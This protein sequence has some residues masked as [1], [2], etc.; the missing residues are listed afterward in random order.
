MSTRGSGGA[1]GDGTRTCSRCGRRQPLGRFHANPNAS[2]GR[3]AMCRDCARDYRQQRRARLDAL[4]SVGAAV[5]STWRTCPRCQQQLPAAD[6]G[7]NLSHEDGL[8]TYCR[9][10]VRT[11]FPPVS[12]DA[13]LRVLRH[14]GG[15]CACCGEPRPEFLGIDPVDV[16]GRAHRRSFSPTRA[17]TLAAWLVAQGLPRGF[18]VLCHNCNVALGLYG[19]CPHDRVRTVVDVAELP[20]P[21]ALEAPG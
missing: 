10:C 9:A 11:A 3:H 18:R 1:H 20:E 16:R 7:R 14:Y 8:A 19:A 21:P 17:G 15:R 5:A 4:R 13:R 2:D 12:A 6:F